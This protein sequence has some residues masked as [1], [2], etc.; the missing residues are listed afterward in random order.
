MVRWHEV[1]NFSAKVCYENEKYEYRNHKFS[2]MR[3][4]PLSKHRVI[5]FEIFCLKEGKAAD[6]Y[7]KN[8][9][10]N[11][12]FRNSSNHISFS[13][14][15]PKT[16]F[17]HLECR[18]EDDKKSYPTNAWVFLKHFCDISRGSDHEDNR[19]DES[20]GKI[21]IIPVTRSCY[22][23]DIIKGHGDISN[24]NGF[25]GTP[26]VIGT[27]FWLLFAMF[28]C[29]DFSI[30]FPDNIEE[31]DSPEE[32]K[33]RDLH[34]KDYSKR[35]NNTKDSSPSYSP[36]NRLFPIGSL[37]S[38]GCHPDEDRII[39]AHDKVDEDDVKE[40]KSS[41]WSEEMGEV[42]HKKMKDSEYEENIM[43]FSEKATIF[44]QERREVILCQWT[45]YH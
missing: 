32:L 7:D 42:E 33:S 3:L 43:I 15:F 29:A 17:E 28:M 10:E 41:L 21:H 19:D 24:N 23:K 5:C 34:K 14:S 2:S 30:K 16:F 20:Y 9:G 12:W 22:R 8:E 45:I 1:C 25:D 27:I 31:E 38:A 13:D 39:T 26:E 37:E 40:S 36:E 44:W 18:E 11:A 6:N 35:K 4:G